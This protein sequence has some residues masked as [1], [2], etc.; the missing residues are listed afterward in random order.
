MKLVRE[1]INFKRGL[2]PK[3]AMN[4]GI[5][6]NTIEGFLQIKGFKKI[7]IDYQRRGLYVKFEKDGVKFEFEMKDDIDT[8]STRHCLSWSKGPR[9]FDYQPERWTLDDFNDEDA[10]LSIL[11][12]RLKKYYKNVS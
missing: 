1:N 9:D 10:A 8:A 6:P 7:K 11:K 2:D 5:D 3:R 4:I 12:R